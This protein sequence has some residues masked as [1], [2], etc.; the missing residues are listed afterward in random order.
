[1][2]IKEFFE[3]SC[4]KWFSQRTSQ[5]LAFNQSEWGKS[6][7]WV[8]LLPASD[9]IVIQMCEQQTIDPT[10]AACGVRVTWE[11]FVGQDPDKQLGVTVLVPIED[12]EQ[13]NQGMLLRKTLRPHDSTAT[14]R[15]ILAADDIL[16]LTTEYDGMFSEERLWFASP[17]LRLRSS[18]LKRQ[19]DFCT[20][21]FCSEIRLGDANA[22]PPASS[23]TTR[24][25]R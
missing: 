23:T 13:P 10:S 5:H 16:T 11:G 14:G 9:S 7:L 20:A 15:Y 22:K 25:W 2:D 17:N 21:S 6:D 1:M 8:E 4:G 3:Q 19:D 18:I 24:S 12:A